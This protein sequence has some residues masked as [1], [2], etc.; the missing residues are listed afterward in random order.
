[1]FSENLLQTIIKSHSPL[2]ASL[3]KGWQEFKEPEAK[4]TR[5]KNPSQVLAA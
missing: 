1:M 4:P 5:S 2:Q 3:D